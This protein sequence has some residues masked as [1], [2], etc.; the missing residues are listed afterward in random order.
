MAMFANSF[1][2]LNDLFV[3]E[4]KD[5][6]DAEHQ[7][8]EALPKM[9]EAA[10]NPQLKL[11]FESH[12][13]ETQNHVR[14]LEQVFSQIGCQPERETCAAMKGLISEGQGMINAKGNNTVRDA[15]LISA[16]QRVEHYE[17][18]SYGTVRTLAQQ[19]GFM[20]VARTLQQTLDEEGNADKKLTSIAQSSV[21]VTSPQGEPMNA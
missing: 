6:Y 5:L 4:L 19:L 8:T 2:N 18:A 13:R 1:E 20:D 12:L 9:K 21:N 15:G 16:A 17:M 7:I 10:T 14:R 11:A 3:F